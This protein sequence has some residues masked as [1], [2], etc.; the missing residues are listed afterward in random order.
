MR[1]AAIKPVSGLF[2]NESVFPKT[3]LNNFAN[4]N[5]LSTATGNQRSAGS[6]NYFNEGLYSYFAKA[7]TKNDSRN[8]AA[9]SQGVTK[10]GTA[11]SLSNDIWAESGAK[12]L[13]DNSA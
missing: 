9:E 3:A 6:S 1:D 12:A 5:E 2:N 10:T 7:D 4:L 13:N 11:T 8:F